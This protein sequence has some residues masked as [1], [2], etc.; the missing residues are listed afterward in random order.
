MK[1][2]LD[3]EKSNITIEDG[4]E[5][6]TIPLYSK[7]SFEQLSRWWIKV[8][9]NQKYSYTFTWMGRPVIQAPDD[10]LRVQEVICPA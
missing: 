2:I 5:Q 3:S 7:E 6:R 9:W 1:I 4:D 10:L 8:G